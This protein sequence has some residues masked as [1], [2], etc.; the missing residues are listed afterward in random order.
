[1]QNL[2]RQGSFRQSRLDFVTALRCV[3]QDRRNIGKFVEPKNRSNNEIFSSQL[4][5]VLPFSGRFHVFKLQIN[6]L[7]NVIIVCSYK[8]W[9]IIISLE[10]AARRQNISAILGL[11][12]QMKLYKMQKHQVRL[13]MQ[14]QFYVL[15]Q[16]S[17]YLERKNPN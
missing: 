5:L 10:E 8:R 1:M 7:L 6:L 4:L 11:N 12:S 17:L 15:L 16:I 13:S 3:K 2:S 9:L 14:Y